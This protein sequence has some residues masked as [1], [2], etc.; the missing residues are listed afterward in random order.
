MVCLGNICRSP[1]A[2]GILRNK[3]EKAGLHWIIDSAGTGGYHIGQQPHT[4]SQKVALLNGINISSQQCRQF[5]KDDMV[6]FDKIF[7]MDADNYEE[8]KRISGE[9]WDKQK[10]GLLLDEL[11]PGESRSVPDPWYGTEKDYHI[12]YEMVDKACEQII[13]QHLKFKIQK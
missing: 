8:V 3:A 7:V 5:R 12:V 1:L 13:E 2:E 11:Y 4:L 9:F 6:A 10:V